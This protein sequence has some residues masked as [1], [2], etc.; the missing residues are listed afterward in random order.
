M[1]ASA[2]YNLAGVT[3]IDQQRLVSTFLDLVRIDSPSGE[4]EA[5]ALEVGRRLAGLGGRV[6]RDAYGN[7]I[8]AIGQGGDAFLLGA[9]PGYRRTGPRHQPD[10]RRRPDQDRRLDRARR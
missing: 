2:R 3:M 6:Q 9:P 1:P 5:M 7:L 8:V 10:S 4:E